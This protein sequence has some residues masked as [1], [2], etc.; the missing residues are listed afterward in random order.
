MKYRKLAW[1]ATAV[2]MVAMV[3]LPVAE[4]R[5]ATPGSTVTPSELLDELTVASV[6]NVKY[7]RDRLA[8]D[9][10]ANNDG[11]RTRQEVLKA[12]TRAP[13]SYS[14]GCT[15]VS[16]NWFSY[17]DAQTYTDPNDLE[18]DH[19]V[20]LKEA[21]ISGA[22]AWTDQQ[23]SDYAN[24]LDDPRTLVM[25]TAGVNTA[26]SDKD[27]TAWLPPV[28]E[29]RCQYASDWIAV[30]YR[31]NLTIDPAEKAAL[32]SVIATDCF[33]GAAGWFL[34]VPSVRT[35]TS[36]SSGSVTNF[37]PGTFR[38]SGNDRYG[39]A[40]AISSRFNPGVPVLY[41]ATGENYPDALA[42]SALAGRQ[43]SPLLLVQPGAIPAV[44]WD[45]ILRLQP[46]KIV[47][48]GGLAAISA[49]VATQLGTVAPVLRVSGTDRYDTSR[50]LAQ[51]SGLRA[52]SIFVATGLNF[53]DALS[54]SA[55]AAA[56]QGSVVL[57]PGTNGDVD[58]ATY[59]TF[60]QL[61]ANELLIAGGT[62]VVSPQME[63]ALRS[64][65][66]VSRLAGTDRW[67]TGVAINQASFSSPST[68]YLAVGT[69][70]ADALAGGALAGATQSPLFIVPSN[71]VPDNVSA[72]I[73]SWNPQSI[74]LLG[75]TAV[76]TSGVA[77]LSSCTPPPP[78]PH[79]PA[80]PTSPPTSPPAS[81]GDT[82]NCSDFTTW[83]AAQNWFLTYYPYYGDVARLDGD[84][85][86][87]AC[88]TLPGAP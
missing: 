88:E 7:D 32:T 30:K 83:S 70:Y 74:V 87:V 49:A 46:H 63:T 22:W 50:Q 11:C 27:P 52:S 60:S 21:W 24:D 28:T 80:G 78:P 13:I 26:K 31:W 47:I 79:T 56:K 44:I 65:Y 19:L 10:D 41:I 33:E 76:L 51:Q 69:N 73:R 40:A 18:M 36:P 53:P 5:A 15:I 81:P 35:D 38:L 16:G 57:V 55:A 20:A 1:V 61:G 71:C 54:A 37:G 14:T 29:N 67:G 8:E 23:R 75:G 64:R 43:S 3:A 9:I 34:T 82:K 2:L 48:A 25:V 86:G 84:S 62:S 12:E 45:E 4:A 72:Q 77:S 59:D 68:V 42:A 39:T 6:A 17:Y 85:D 66:T 58:A